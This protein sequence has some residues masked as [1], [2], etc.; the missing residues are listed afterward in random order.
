[1]RNKENIVTSKIVNLC[2]DGVSSALRSAAAAPWNRQRSNRTAF[3]AALGSSGS[4]I[5][6]DERSGWRPRQ[7]G[8]TVIHWFH[9]AARSRAQARRN[10]ARGR[11]EAARISDEDHR[12]LACLPL[13]P[14]IPGAT[15]GGAPGSVE[16]AAKLCGLGRDRVHLPVQGIDPAR[17]RGAPSAQLGMGVGPTTT[18]DT[19]EVAMVVRR[20]LVRQPG[21]RARTDRS[22]IGRRQ[23]AVRLPYD[24]R[25]STVAFRD[26]R[27]A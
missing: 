21:F 18:T 22:H 4:A 9:Q 1:L 5:A 11:L 23:T 19:Q 10:T 12:P 2:R 8:R 17:R 20:Y 26:A 14:V 27:E 15:L 16:V 13:A 7:A 24:P 3:Q 6:A 25:G